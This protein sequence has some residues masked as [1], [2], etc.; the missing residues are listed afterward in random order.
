[1][2]TF[3]KLLLS[4]GLLLIISFS[5]P[6]TTHSFSFPSKIDTKQERMNIQLVLNTT[7]NPSPNLTVDGVLGTKSIQAIKAFQ[8]SHGLVIDGKVGPITRNALTQA[9]QTSS[10]Q[11]TT[12]IGCLPGY[13][14]NPQT[15]KPCS[16]A[17]NTTQPQTTQ[18]CTGL[19]TT[20]CTI[21]HGT[22]IK[23]R[24]CYSGIWSTYG[25][26]TLKSCNQGYSQSDNTCIITTIP[27]TP[28][29]CIPE[30]SSTTCLNKCGDQTNNCGS[31]VNCGTCTNPIGDI[32]NV[33]LK[34]D[35][36]NN[37]LGQYLNNEWLADW[38]NPPWANRRESLEIRKDVNDAENKTKTLWIDFPE[39]SLGPSEGGTQWWSTLPNKYDEI[40]FSYD[41]K[42]MGGFQ[43]Q[44]GGK[45]PGMKGGILP[46]FD[47]PTGYDGFVILMMFKGDVPVFYIYYPD[48]Y[49][50]TYGATFKWGGEQDSFYLANKNNTHLVLD[51]VDSVAAKFTSG[52]WDN[53][54][55]RVVLNTVETEGVP[56]YDGILEAYF[57][58]KLVLQLSHIL[59]RLSN[60]IK[61]DKLDITTFFGGDTDA[62]RN[63]IA[64]WVKFDNFYLFDYKSGVNVPRGHTLSP[65]N[66]I[67][68]LPSS[69]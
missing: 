12:T 22:G 1:M 67:I 36:E 31:S 26:C 39:K 34:R 63:P 44:S 15:G 61:I 68:E 57:N 37:T 25:S 9:Q 42:F 65:V 49:L 69:L 11:V 30:S 2:K 62:W 14:Y 58:G 54:T 23:S 38:F 59:W 28:P 53:I 51:Y 41:V 47:K 50:A 24:T 21:S 64:E 32:F 16:T 10:I 66:R 17:T 18:S 48:N 56:V 40:Y 13:L 29:T 19:T 6:L 35:F 52:Q 8:Q 43:Y 46:G 33:Y 20:P 4:L 5:L 3:S 60:Y 45:I 27:V 55:Y 7:M